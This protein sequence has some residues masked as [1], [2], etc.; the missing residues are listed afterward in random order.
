MNEMLEFV[1]FRPVANMRAYGLGVQE[2][3]EAFASGEQA[4][5]HG[6]GNIGSATYMAYLPEHGVSIVVMVNA[7]PT[8]CA[9]TVAKGLIKEVLRDMGVLGWIPYVPFFPT[10]FILCCALF[11]AIVAVGLRLK[12]KRRRA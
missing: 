3:E 11:S 5:G 6:G 2:F 12:G 9:D 7:F 1:E 10:G 4:I 8:S